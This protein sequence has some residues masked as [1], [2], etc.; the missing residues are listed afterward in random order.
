[1]SE[2]ILKALMQLFALIADIHDDNVITAREKKI[3][4]LF[5]S[6]HLNNE[7]VT[8]YMKMF[9]ENLSQFNSERIVK[10]SLKDRKRTSLNAMR[11]LSICEQINEELRQSQ[12]IYLLVQLTDFISM[13]SEI[14]ENALDFLFTVATAFNIPENEYLNIKSFILN[15]LFKYHDLSR[16]LV[17]NNITEPENDKI[18]HH[19]IPNLKGNLLFLHIPSTNTFIMRYSGSDD[20]YLNGQNIISGQTGDLL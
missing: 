3:V 2:Q 4:R 8:R 19:C 17:I 20:L 13:G 18:K 14:T 7:L 12:K 6:R 15:S 1:M 16:I 5:L 11:I 9:E 10:G